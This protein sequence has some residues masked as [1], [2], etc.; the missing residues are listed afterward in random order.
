MLLRGRLSLLVPNL[1]LEGGLRRPSRRVSFHILKDFEDYEDNTH[2]RAIGPCTTPQALS[3]A[4]PESGY[5]TY[6]VGLTDTTDDME[7]QCFLD[8]YLQCFISSHQCCPSMTV[9]Q[10]IF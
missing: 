5:C 6:R 4:C 7:P 10:L 3:L 2:P 8:N 1:H 9:V